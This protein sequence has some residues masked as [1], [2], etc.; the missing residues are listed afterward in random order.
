MLPS[1]YNVILQ[2][3]SSELLSSLSTVI[4]A[5]EA[6]STQM[7]KG[8]FKTLPAAKL[9]NEYGPTEATVWCIAHEIQVE[10][11]EG[12]IPIGKPV[13]GADIFLLDSKGNQ[14][15]HGAIGEIYVGG[16]GLAGEYL[17]RPGID[18]RGLY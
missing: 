14:V 11:T 4:V 7:V 6:C 17:N 10:D 16:P 5:G 18:G 8:H 15:P 9:Y 13:A 12:I 1:L 2:H 3:S